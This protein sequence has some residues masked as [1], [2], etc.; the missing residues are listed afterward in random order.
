MTLLGGIDR[1]CKNSSISLRRIHFAPITCMV[2]LL[3]SVHSR[4]SSTLHV[5]RRGRRVN[6]V[7][8]G[9]TGIAA[10]TGRSIDDRLDAA[11]NDTVAE[12]NIRGAAISFFDRVIQSAARMTLES[13][14]LVMEWM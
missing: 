2:L 13:Q 12:L 8:G 3:L 14:M 4:T 7:G 6:A 5:S 1:R 10:G 11:M 9:H